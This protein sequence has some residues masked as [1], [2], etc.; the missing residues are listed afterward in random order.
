MTT[1]GQEQSIVT[2]VLE[3]AR[4]Y[5]LADMALDSDCDWVCHE[6][7]HGTPGDECELSVRF[8]RT[9]NA[10]TAASRKLA[11]GKVEAKP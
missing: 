4:A 11:A 10:L 9:L 6:C 2:E 5:A 7:E 8:E 3:A 1:S